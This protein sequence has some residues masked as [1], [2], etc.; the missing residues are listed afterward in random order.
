M[1]MIIW[2][3][4]KIKKKR[5]KPKPCWYLFSRYTFNVSWFCTADFTPL[6]SSIFCSHCKKSSLLIFL[7][8]LQEIF[9]PNNT[10]NHT[11][12]NFTYIFNHFPHRAHCCKGYNTIV[13]NLISTIQLIIVGNIL[14]VSL[15]GRAL[16][17]CDKGI[18]PTLFQE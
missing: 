11:W 12:Q 16:R 15:V 14:M 13:S 18:L 2:K 6:F 3:E 7:F 8:T 10:Y 5:K 1:F 4:K 9:T 17:R